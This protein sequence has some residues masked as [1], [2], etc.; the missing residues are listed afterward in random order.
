M[1][2]LGALLGG[3]AGGALGPYG[4]MAGGGLGGAM[5]GQ[6]DQRA[7]A[8]LGGAAGA[9]LGSLGGMVGGGAGGS[10]LGLLIAKLLGKDEMAGAAM[11]GVGGSA[12]GSILGAGLGGGAGAQFAEK[13]SSV[14]GNN[15]QREKLAYAV[16]AFE[17]LAEYDVDPGAF[18]QLAVDTQDP[19]LCKI[20]QAIVDLDDFL[21]TAGR[22]QGA[23]EIFARLAQSA[24]A[25]GDNVADFMQ[26]SAQKIN[27]GKN[28]LQEG[29]DQLADGSWRMGGGSPVE[30][31]ASGGGAGGAMI[32]SQTAMEGMGEEAGG[33]SPALLAALGITG[34]GA[35]AAG[36]HG[37]GDADTMENKLRNLLGIGG[38]QSRFSNALGL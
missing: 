22:G 10:L 9:G 18:I 11:G 13:N 33:M 2:N 5:G 1:N 36:V 38:T 6:P 20:A 34:V 4:A 24:K 23:Q 37:A 32:P 21:K 8:G 16:G 26:G 15:M 19:G 28:N 3:A 12:L 30:S 31:G 27:R 7:M 14:Q 29:T 35:G 25:Q 17:K